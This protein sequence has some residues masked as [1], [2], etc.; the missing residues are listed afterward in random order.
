MKEIFIKIIGYILKKIILYLGPVF[1][2]IGQ[3]LAY[4]YPILNELICLRDKC[5]PLNNLEINYYINKYPYLNINKEYLAAGSV[6]VVYK[7]ILDNKY[8]AIKIKRPI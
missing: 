7:G 4:D 5:P 6:A 2:K 1:I 8:I 3:L